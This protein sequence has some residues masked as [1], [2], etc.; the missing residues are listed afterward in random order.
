VSKKIKLL[1]GFTVIE[2]LVVISIIGLLSTFVLVATK[3]ATD[4]AKIAKIM[5]FS[6]SINSALGSE[7]A[8]IWNFDELSNGLQ[9]NGITIKDSSG[10][11]NDG[12]LFG[13]GGNRCS[14]SDGIIRKALNAT[15]DGFCWFT[16]SNKLS[17]SGDITIEAWIKSDIPIDSHAYSGLEIIKR[18]NC[19]QLNRTQQGDQ[20]RLV[21]T[22]GNWNES[23]SVSSSDFSFELGKWTHIAATYDSISGQVKFFVNGDEIISDSFLA[24]G[25]KVDDNE[26]PANNFLYINAA[27]FNYRNDSI[28]EVRIYKE[29]FNRSEIQKHYAEGAAKHGVAID[30]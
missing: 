26:S 27:V 5:Q 14:V 25:F 21:F 15:N 6:A 3:G 4:K 13:P 16:V 2:L 29:A 19:Y 20:N 10:S 30:K 8:G 17:I 24:P 9:A 1:K 28:D 12:I 7:A 23:Y 11:G 22:G 18:Q